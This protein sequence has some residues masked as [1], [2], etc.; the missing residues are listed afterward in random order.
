MGGNGSDAS[1]D[2]WRED[3]RRRGQGG[4]FGG[5]GG[6]GAGVLGWSKEARVLGASERRAKSHLNLSPGGSGW[7]DGWREFAA[8]LQFWG[9]AQRLD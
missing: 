6:I 2:F 7:L 5:I 1:S 4:C 9:T 8:W 3:A